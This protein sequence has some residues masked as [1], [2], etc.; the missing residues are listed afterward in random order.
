M[1]AR[2]L[3]IALLIVWVSVPHAA[4]QRSATVTISVVAT[5]DLHGGVLSRGERGGIAMLGG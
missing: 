3:A 1:A 2:R 5:S 4:A